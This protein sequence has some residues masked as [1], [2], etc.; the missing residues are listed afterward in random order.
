MDL[1]AAARALVLG[2][3]G[4]G[5]ET[6]G[7]RGAGLPGLLLHFRL[8]L[9]RKNKTHKIHSELRKVPLIRRVSKKCG[10]KKKILKI[11]QP[12]EWDSPAFAPLLWK[13]KE[14]NKKKRD[15]NPKTG[16]DVGD[17]PYSGSARCLFGEEIQSARR[18]THHRHNPNYIRSKI[19][20]Y[21]GS[22]S[23]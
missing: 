3:S 1:Q 10:R 12:F 23:I 5:A 17:S 9:L 7:L 21:Y 22:S 14:K 2:G 18:V 11:I 19:P 6:G 13:K 20:N 15:L 8:G 16:P 4:R